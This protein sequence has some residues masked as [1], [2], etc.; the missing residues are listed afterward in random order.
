LNES[1]RRATGALEQLRSGEA[2]LL[3]LWSIA[4][5]LK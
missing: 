2:T 1:D 3:R 5:E 4:L